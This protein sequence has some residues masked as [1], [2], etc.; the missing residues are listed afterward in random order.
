[1]DDSKAFAQEIREAVARQKDDPELYKLAQK[2]FLATS[3]HRYTYRFSWLGRPIVQRPQDILAMQEL[4]W[5][6]KPDMILETGIARGGSMV[7]YASMLELLGGDR[8]V[9]GIDIDIRAHNRAAIEVHPMYGRIR[10]LEGSSIDPE[11]VAQ[12]RDMAMDRKHVLVCL[13]SLHTEAHVLAELRA[14]S[15]LVPKGGYLVVLDTVIENMAEESLTNRPWSRTNNP[16]TALRFFLKEND[17]FQVDHEMG[18]Q[19]YEP[20][21]LP[22]MRWQ[23]VEEGVIAFQDRR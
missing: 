20:N 19:F 11:I 12:A 15:D 5:Q 18:R 14:Y 21:S 2:W 17:R 10:M 7:F 1:M 6:L 9:L 23:Q 4:I 8:F 3:R 16:A 22:R 13:D